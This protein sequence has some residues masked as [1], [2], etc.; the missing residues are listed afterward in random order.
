MK[1]TMVDGNYGR[2]KVAFAGDT[3]HEL[4]EQMLG[5]L[6]SVGI[7]KKENLKQKPAEDAETK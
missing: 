7:L 2:F 5:F 4:F 1:Q 3:P 6:M